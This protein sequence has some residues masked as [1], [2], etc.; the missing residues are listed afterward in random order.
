MY[1]FIQNAVIVDGKKYAY[2]SN[3]CFNAGHGPSLGIPSEVGLKPY[4]YKVSSFNTV[5]TKIPGYAGEITSIFFDKLDPSERS[6][7]IM[8]R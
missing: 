6:N 2:H 4:M 3:C 8:D 5:P 7:M 1:E